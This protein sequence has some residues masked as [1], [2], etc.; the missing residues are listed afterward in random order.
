MTAYSS[1]RHCV[2]KLLGLADSHAIV[3]TED[4]YDD[5]G[6][7]LLA[8]GAAISRE[9]QDRLLLRKLRAPLESSLTVEGGLS[10]ADVV[11][12]ALDLIG[13]IPELE[14]VAGARAAREIL[15]DGRSLHIPPPLM[16]LLTCARHADPASYRRT[17]IVTA[18][19]AGIAAQLEASPGE[20]QMLLVAS[21][22]HDL[23]EIYINP[24][25]LQR[26]GRLTPREWKHVATHPHVGQLLIR[27]LTSLP[28]GVAACVGQHHERHDGSGYPAQLAR[29]EQHFLAG[30]IAVADAAAALIARGETCGDRISLALRIVPE[31]FER[32][33]A[34]VLIRSLRARGKAV[35]VATGSAS[36]EQAQRLL[37]RLESAGDGLN[38]LVA[39]SPV[40]LVVEVCHKAAHL[41]E[42]FA[43]SLRATGILDAAVLSGEDIA[44]QGLLEEMR[45]IVSEVTW[46]ARNLARNIYLAVDALKDETVLAQ[47][48][49]IIDLL[50]AAPEG[51][52]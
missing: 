6:F 14:A 45:Q 5:Q 39:G 37:E 30:W 8:K 50:D 4:I 24:E 18:L 2:E 32:A 46:R 41:L 23:G 10:V 3:A 34:D 49:A 29:E 11:G 28:H 26:Q 16:L 48:G 25:F 31:E 13:Q 42:G 51:A 17:Q 15:R 35:P 52:E 19:C 33:P 9:M 20:T 27:S 36:V 44:D 22:L 47:V 7:K 43:K 1:N 38:A 40:G 21:A 12:G